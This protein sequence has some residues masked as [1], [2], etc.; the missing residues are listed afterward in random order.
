MIYKPFQ[1]FILENT[2]KSL[3]PSPFKIR[4]ICFLQCYSH[5]PVTYRTTKKVFS[6]STRKA[7]PSLPS[8]KT[9]QIKSKEGASCS[10]MHVCV[11]RA[12]CVLWACSCSTRMFRPTGHKKCPHTPHPPFCRHS[13]FPSVLTL[14]GKK[15]KSKPNLQNLEKIL[16]LARVVKPTSVNWEH[17]ATSNILFKKKQSES[18]APCSLNTGFIRTARI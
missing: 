10:P 4:P 1:V 15:K 3:K 6:Q 2:K 13:T 5:P 11:S 7:L 17:L 12:V 9:W 14:L 16:T 8:V 18:Q